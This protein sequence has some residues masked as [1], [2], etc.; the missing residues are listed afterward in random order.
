[1]LDNR[2][3]ITN[4]DEYEGLGLLVWFAG[5]IACVFFMAAIKFL[6]LYTAVK[7]IEIEFRI[8]KK[9]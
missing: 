2:L 1:M 9:I 4:A 6:K 3:T 5:L 7:Y 8:R